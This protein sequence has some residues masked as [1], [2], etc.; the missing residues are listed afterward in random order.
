MKKTVLT[1]FVLLLS[2]VSMASETKICKK[3]YQT[4]EDN[5]IES[6][7]GNSSDDCSNGSDFG[8]AFQMCMEDEFPSVLEAYNKKNPTKKVKCEDM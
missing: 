2:Q 1:A 6:M 5:C 4:A 7:C 3:L 8:E